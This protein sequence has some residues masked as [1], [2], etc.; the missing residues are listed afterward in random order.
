MPLHHLAQRM[1][2]ALDTTALSVRAPL[3]DVQHAV[4]QRAWTVRRHRFGTLRMR[5][6]SW[7]HVH[8]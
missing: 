6:C 4:D 5:R 1:G 3:Q 2:I 8:E 7:C